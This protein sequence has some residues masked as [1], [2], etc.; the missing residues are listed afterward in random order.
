VELDTVWGSDRFEAG[1]KGPEITSYG[2]NVELAWLSMKAAAVLGIPEA[3]AAE[4]ALPLFRHTLNRGVDPE[5]GGLYVEGDRNGGPTDTDKEFW[6][7]AEALAGFALAYRLTGDAGYLGGFDKV[8]SFVFRHLVH[9]EL[10]EW[11]PL[12]DRKG[13]LKRYY[14]GHEWKTCYHTLRGISLAVRHLESSP[15]G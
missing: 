8:R 12:A 6:Q 2:H 5:F 1:E 13:T 3:A 11:F 14:L 9:P 15:E 7:Q 4:R 10:G